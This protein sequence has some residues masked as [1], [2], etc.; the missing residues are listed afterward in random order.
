MQT[1]IEK[2]ESIIGYHFKNRKLSEYALTHPSY[3]SKCSYE[4]LEFLGDLVLDA[5]VGINLFRQYPSAEESFLTDLKSAYVNSKYL[6]N[7]GIVLKLR[8]FIRHKN[9]EVPKMD[10]FVESIIGAIYLDS[11]WRK[12]EIF[13]KKFIL[14]KKIDPIRNHKNILSSVSKKHFGIE[15][16]YEI[17][18]EKGLPHKRIYAVKTKIPGKRYV[19]KGTGRTKKDAEMQAAEDL[20]RKLGKHKFLN[21]LSNQK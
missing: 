1:K 12:S 19:G 4:R 8:K 6:H 20:L 10:N 7:V 21:I 11:G 5:V 13:I 9:Y 15:P 16:G 3:D 2:M 14:N 18:S 17:V